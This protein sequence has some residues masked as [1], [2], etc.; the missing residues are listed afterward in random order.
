M[1][2]TVGSAIVLLIAGV[3]QSAP[4]EV[5]TPTSHPPRIRFLSLAEARAIA[6]QNGKC[7][8]PSLLSPGL[9]VNGSVCVPDGS[10]SIGIRHNL[11]IRAKNII[12]A[13]IPPTA[14]RAE[15]E[16]NLNQMLLNVE[17]AYWNLYGSYWQLHS[18]EQGMRFAYES[19]K[20]VGA[21]F[22]AGTANR[23]AMAQAE[24]QYHLFR[25][26]R[27]QALDTVLDNERQ[28]RAMLGLP[29]EDGTR[30]APSD[31]PLLVEKQPDWDKALTETLKNR[32]ELHL[33]R[34]DLKAAQLNFLVTKNVVVPVLRLVKI[35][36]PDTADG[37]AKV[38]TGAIL[39]RCMIPVSNLSNSSRVREAQLQ[40]ARA[41][42]VLQD[43][44]L[45]AERFLGLYYRRMSSSYLQIK[46]AHAQREAFATQ[47]R[48][49]TDKYRDGDKDT[50]LSLVLEAQRFWADSLATECQ[51]AVTYN[52][53][54]AGWAY[55]QGAILEHA[56]V[57]LA[58]KPPCG[59]ANVSAVRYER[60]RTQKQVRREPAVRANDALSAPVACS[61]PALWKRFP[62]PLHAEELSSIENVSY[63]KDGEPKVRQ[64]EGKVPDTLPPSPKHVERVPF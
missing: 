31:V 51:A 64:I 11:T 48:A 9:G 40:L 58:E 47:V 36:G 34:Q 39:T 3:A 16:R 42:L 28:L 32:P 27:I 6:L 4:P 38:K 2:R 57:T 60:K 14:P 24:G 8:Q 43:Q 7:G 52:N 46:A 49:C 30:L 56:H 45:K 10:G 22:K 44:E 23:G 1:M 37:A 50:P 61:L 59:C 29:I 12:V 63:Q 35:E 33:A 53:A 26:Q 19:W 55:A 41:Y 18:R 5:I 62:P 54:Q 13:G 15:L 20:L 21:K 25:S 17:N